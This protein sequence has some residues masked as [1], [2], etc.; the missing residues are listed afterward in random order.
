MDNLVVKGPECAV[1]PSHVVAACVTFFLN[2]ELIVL[3]CGAVSLRDL[4]SR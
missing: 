3:I 1:V 2:S 4:I